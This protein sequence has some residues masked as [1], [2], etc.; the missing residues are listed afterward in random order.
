[1]TDAISLGNIARSDGTFRLTGTASDL[2]T[3]AIV[4]ATYESKR[5]AAVRL[6]RK[7]EVNDAKTAAYSDLRTNLSDLQ[8][9]VDGLRNP[10]GFLG[11]EDNVFEQKQVFLSGTTSA[12]PESVVGVVAGNTAD[13][14]AFEL[15]VQQL[16]TAQKLSAGTAN[17][18]DQT[19][20]DA[21]NGGAAFSGT[22]DLGLAGGA[23][24][25]VA[26]DGTMTFADIRT[27]INAASATTGV[28]ASVLQVSDTDQRLV[29]SAEDTNKAISITDSSGITGGFLTSELQAAQPALFEVDGIALSRDNNEVDDAV[30]GVTLS[31]FKAEPGATVDISIEPSLGGAKDRIVDFVNAYN[32]FR[33]FVDQQSVV[34]EDGDVSADSIL[35][36]DP[37]L[38]RLTA[39]LSALT[40][41]T[42]DGLDPS[43]ISTL[44]DVGITI[45][46]GNRL[47]VDD[48]KLDQ[49]LI[50]NLDELRRIFEFDAVSVPATLDVTGRS[51]ALGATSFNVEIVD[52]DNDGV[53]ESATIDGIAAE[54]SNRSIS[55]PDG[56]A[57]EGLSFFWS[58]T[59]SE[60]VSVDVSQGIAD[61]LY[62]RLEDALD[63]LNGELQEMTTTLEET[64]A[65]YLEDIE[66]IELRAET[67]RDLLI[68]KFAAMEEALSLANTMLEQLRAQTAAWSSQ[69]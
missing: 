19:L 1:M 22:L 34:T 15:E 37:T 21:L 7:I 29:L 3:S 59:G 40:G 60:T 39:D 48:T 20:A 46:P 24:A 63:P 49:G 27:T 61:K 57:Y 50:G 43:A 35:F 56:S 28:R 26:I 4:E 41:D 42:V 68:E 47:A 58:G 30:S 13:S 11:V 45:D 51:N 65:G 31:L 14:G 18:V 44:R 12:A 2:D 23:T 66:R 53:P 55:A 64:N 54:I 8:N 6:E 9:A 33:D 36:G 62:N 5:F 32:A 67:A 16:A 25:S 10:P 52:S 17:S 69:S 38:R